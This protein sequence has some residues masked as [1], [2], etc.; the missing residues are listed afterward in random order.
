MQ[1]HRV[2]PGITGWAQVNGWRGETDTLDKMEKRVECDLYYIENWSLW[3]DLKII[4]MTVFKGFVHQRAYWG[5]G[6]RAEARPANVVMGA[7]APSPFEDVVKA[8]P[9]AFTTRNRKSAIFRFL[10]FQWLTAIEKGD[11]SLH[12]GGCCLLRPPPFGRGLGWGLQT[13]LLSSTRLLR[14]FSRSSAKNTAMTPSMPPRKMAISRMTRLG[15]DVGLVDS[16]GS[17]TARVSTKL[18]SFPCNSPM[19]SCC[20]AILRFWSLASLVILA[21]LS[22]TMALSLFW[23]SS[24]LLVS[25]FSP[26]SAWAICSCC[27]SWARLLSSSCFWIAALS[28][29]KVMNRRSLSFASHLR[30]CCTSL[31]IISCAMAWVSFLTFWAALFCRF[32]ASLICVSS[33]LIWSLMSSWLA[34]VFCSFSFRMIAWSLSEASLFFSPWILFSAALISTPKISGLLSASRSARASSSAFSCSLI[35]AARVAGSISSSS[36]MRASDSSVCRFFRCQP[37][38]AKRRLVVPSSREAALLTRR[39]H[40]ARGEAK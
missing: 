38:R 10:H 30:F 36:R 27:S 6:C 16:S 9:W 25:F 40:S 28:F 8:L 29:S 34:A 5:A 20:S 39:A 18:S 32:I 1:R 35:S 31:S 2:K 17:T 11:A 33:S 14:T 13:V 4:V 7:H 23:S 22:A 15:V 12:R 26:A 24:L 19:V 21:S 37:W 3:L